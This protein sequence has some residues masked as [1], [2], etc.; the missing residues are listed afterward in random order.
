MRM[1]ILCAALVAFACEKTPKNDGTEAPK[2]DT[3]GKPPAGKKGADPENGDF[4]LEEATKGLAGTG[5]LYAEIT[6]ELGT[7]EC[8]LYDEQAPRTVASFVGL[9]R[10]VRPWK[11]PKT[12]EWVT[13]TPYFDG[14]AFHRVIPEFMIQGGD[15]VS[16]DYADPRAG[17]GGPG[18]SLPDET[19]EELTF[20]RAGRLAMANAGHPKTGG[21]QFFITEVPKASLDKV[22]GNPRRNGYTIFGQCGN[23]EVVKAI[24]R[25]ARNAD[26]KP[27]APVT[28]KI[29]ISRR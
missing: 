7:I 14:L 25:V 9:A 27:D 1:T 6:T 24:A 3:G 2:G 21:S 26:D 16:R 19:N 10:G 17:M 5:K 22:E 23:E 28:M 12:N 8:E 20:D 11:D 15:A 18:Y 4:T 29:K 13:G